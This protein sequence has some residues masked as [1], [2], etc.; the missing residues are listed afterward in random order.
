M[1]VQSCDGL[2]LSDMS[3]ASVSVC[4]ASTQFCMPAACEDVAVGIDCFCFLDGVTPT[5]EPLPAGCLNSGELAMSVPS[6]LELPLVVVK[7]AN[8][9]QEVRAARPNKESSDS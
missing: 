6:S 4:A 3:D 8:A 5:T 9:T 2:E 1:F 7:P